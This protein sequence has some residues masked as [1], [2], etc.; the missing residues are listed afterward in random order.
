[1]DAQIGVAVRQPRFCSMTAL[2]HKRHN[3]QMRMQTM[4]LCED[5]ENMNIL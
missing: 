1:M 3:R 4:R 2:A 5:K